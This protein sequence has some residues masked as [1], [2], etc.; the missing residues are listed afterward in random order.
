MIYTHIYINIYIYVYVVHI[1]LNLGLNLYK[2]LPNFICLL[3]D[4]ILRHIYINI[5]YNNSLIIILMNISNMALA[6]P[7][8]PVLELAQ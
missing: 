6:N 3:K 8:L 4:H 7:G 5:V 2:L 1:C